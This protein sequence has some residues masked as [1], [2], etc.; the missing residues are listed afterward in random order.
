MAM[1]IAEQ[2]H[3]GI[4]VPD[5]KRAKPRLRTLLAQIL[6]SFKTEFRSLNVETA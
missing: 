5:V 6:P 2:P 1:F 3:F 4:D